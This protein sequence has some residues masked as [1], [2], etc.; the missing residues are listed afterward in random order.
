M[1]CLGLLEIKEVEVD[2]GLKL[3]GDAIR[4]GKRYCCL[5][6][7]EISMP[8]CVAGTRAGHP[9]LVWGSPGGSGV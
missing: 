4:T 7:G 2:L 6:V 9:S 8:D 1:K 3:E 5:L